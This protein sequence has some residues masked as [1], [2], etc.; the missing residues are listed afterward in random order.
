MCV[1][2]I[3]RCIQVCVSWSDIILQDRKANRRR[4]TY[5]REQKHA[6]EVGG[7]VR[8]RFGVKCV[9]L[10]CLFQMGGVVRVA[11]AETRLAV[12]CR[13]ALSSVQARAKTPSTH[14]HSPAAGSAPTHT[15]LSSKRQQFLQVFT[16]T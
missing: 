9:T 16:Q 13:S 12:A 2:H 6:L 15:P 14:T 4:R 11:D 5:E 10:V 3:H 7:C 8:E 1:T